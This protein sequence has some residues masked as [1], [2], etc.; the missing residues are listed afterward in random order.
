MD[1]NKRWF[2]RFCPCRRK[3]F[4]IF[5]TQG[6]A[7]LCPGLGAC[8]AFSPLLK[9]MSAT[10]EHLRNLNSESTL[11]SG[12]NSEPTFKVGSILFIFLCTKQHLTKFFLLYLHT[13][14]REYGRS[15][16]RC[17]TRK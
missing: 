8:W 5:I 16:Q 10:S 14:G 9:R 3:H 15:S 1:K 17:F 4:D 7:S 6:A 11:E 12:L 13:F 2:L